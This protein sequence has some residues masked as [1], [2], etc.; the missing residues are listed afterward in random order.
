MGGIGCHRRHGHVPGIEQGG[1]RRLLS[2]IV[3]EPGAAHHRA[4][5]GRTGVLRGEIHGQAASGGLE[6]VA[7]VLRVVG[8]VHGGV[9]LRRQLLLRQRVGQP[10]PGGLPLGAGVL[11]FKEIQPPGRHA[12]AR[13]GAGGGGQLVRPVP[14]VVV[15]GQAGED[16]LRAGVVGQIGEIG[17]AAVPLHQQ[18]VQTGLLRVQTVEGRAPVG[19]GPQQA[20]GG[21]E[22]L[23]RAHRQLAQLAV[24]GLGQLQDLPGLPGVPA[25]QDGALRL[26]APVA[27]H[28]GQH[29]GAAGVH[30]AQLPALVG[31]GEGDPFP[32]GPA[33]GGAEHGG[34]VEVAEAEESDLVGH[35]T[36][37]GGKPVYRFRLRH[38][39]GPPRLRPGAAPVVG[40]VDVGVRVAHPPADGEHKPAVETVHHPAGAG[41]QA[42]QVG[43]L[44]PARQILVGPL[45]GHGDQGV[46]VRPLRIAGVADAQVLRIP[47]GLG[48]VGIN[49]KVIV[50]VASVLPGV[51]QGVVLFLCRG[52]TGLGDPHHAIRKV[53]EGQ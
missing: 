38:H 8:A 14:V 21:A 26:A 10:G 48:L 12:G 25:E 46:Q 20:H 22:P 51:G 1:D 3:L 23:L 45:A 44:I 2:Q 35:K 27:R 24:L 15:Q 36:G 49:R 16:D 33:V 41:Q 34:A 11:P 7:P 39:G 13:A 9:D 29:A 31:Q 50:L 37:A 47:L 18:A 19:Q 6:Q 17:Q 43:G 53:S 5:Q 42:H 30:P 40:A 4:A 28:H 52:I 32:G